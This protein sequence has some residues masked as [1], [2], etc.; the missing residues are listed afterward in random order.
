TASADFLS[1]AAES[2]EIETL[3]DEGETT[4][5]NNSSAITMLDYEDKTVI[6][7]ADA[8]IPALD[9][10]AD[11]LDGRG[12]RTEQLAFIQVPHHGSRRN[13]GPSVL[14]RLLGP[15]Q[16]NEERR[17]TA[18]VSCAPDGEPKHPAK[19]VAN[20]FRRRGSPVHA[21]QGSSK[22]HHH[23]APDRGWSKSEPLPLYLEVED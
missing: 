9:R 4:P 12:Y 11:E 6:F 20:A 18:F 5:L 21:T 14:D 7:T 13:V 2:L 10:A 23:D 16:V 3:T 22:R 17:V 15:K 19:K 1:R 8:G